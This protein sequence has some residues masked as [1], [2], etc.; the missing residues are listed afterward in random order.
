MKNKFNQGKKLSDEILKQTQD[1]DK[2]LAWEQILNEQAQ[3]QVTCRLTIPI[4]CQTYW[5]IAWDVEY[6]GWWQITR[7]INE[8]LLK[9]KNI[10]QLISK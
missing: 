9:T 3:D 6:Q 10:S 2:Y 1:Q 5:Q 7:H 4:D 8:V